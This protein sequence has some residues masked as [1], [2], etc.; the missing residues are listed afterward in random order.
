MMNKKL[1]KIF[2][3]ILAILALLIQVSALESRDSVIIDRYFSEITVET[4]GSLK[5]SF[6]IVTRNIATKLGVTSIELHER[7]A[8][9]TAWSPTATYTL[10]EYPELQ[11]SNKALYEASVS[12]SSPKAGY[13]YRAYVIFYAT[14]GTISE[15]KIYRTNIV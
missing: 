3:A 15:T 9:T 1:T 6:S 4:S 13:E 5:I 2:F 12:Y 11:A 14:D 7:K 10:R 8:G